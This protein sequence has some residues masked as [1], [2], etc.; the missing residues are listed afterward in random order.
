V[1]DY[2]TSASCRPDPAWWASLAAARRPPRWPCSLHRA[3]GSICA[4]QRSHRGQPTL[5]QGISNLPLRTCA[6]GLRYVP[7]DPW[8]PSS[9][10]SG[11]ERV[12]D[13]LAS[14]P[15]PSPRRSS[16]SASLE[17]VELGADPRAAPLPPQLWA[18]RAAGHDRMACVPATRRWRAGRIPTRARRDHPG[19]DPGGLALLRDDDAC[20][21]VR[22]PRPGG[23][24]KM[25]DRIVRLYGRPRGGRAARTDEVIAR[26]RHPSTRRWCLPSPTFA[27]PPL[28]RCAASRAVSGRR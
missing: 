9:V 13:L 17:R 5:G 24:A 18:A 7:Q 4:G 3:V 12:M 27:R 1:V 11:G 22:L 28:L 15:A 20:D 8:A 23:V 10:A 6:A 26:P 25:S 19:P 16:R 21:G 2:V 14:A